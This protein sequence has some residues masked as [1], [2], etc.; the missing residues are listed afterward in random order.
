ME[1]TTI[2]IKSTSLYYREGS[3]DKV[4][5]AAIV[6][7]GPGAFT[8]DV[9]WGRRGQGLQSGTK[10]K[11]PV[12]REKAIGIYEKVVAEK[13]GKGYT[14]S[15]D[16]KAY[17]RSKDEGRAT[18]ILPQLLAPIGEPESRA[19]IDDADFVAQEK[20]DG[21]RVIVSADSEGVT[22]INRRGLVI[23]LPGEVVEAARATVD[24]IGRVRIVLDGELLG[25]TFVVFDVLVLEGVPVQDATYAGRLELLSA[26]VTPTPNGA[27]RPVVTSRGADKEAFI[28]QLRARNAEGVV[29]KH[30]ESRSR[31][32]RGRIGDVDTHVKLKFHESASFV[33]TGLNEKRSIAIGLFSGD[34]LVGV[35]NVTI[36][37]SAPVPA[38]G[39]VV[40]VRYLYAFSGGSVYQPVYLGERADVT[41]DECV[42][43]Q[44]KF[45]PGC[46]E[47]EP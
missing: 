17:A 13:M 39:T 24:A 7:R 30:L 43:E 37:P 41:P 14:P 32:G 12:G 44:L 25:T 20:H 33:C 2:V 5:R 35:G 27:I 26:F 36:P 47:P 10:T 29:F 6:E 16:G 42:L 38:V 46:D 15:E 21:R 31:P 23:T 11:Q 19:F 1:T 40:E 9:A 34:D 22:G 28:E 4:Y 18:G 8:V 3:S 45:R